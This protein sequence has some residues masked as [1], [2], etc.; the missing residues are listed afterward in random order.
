MVKEY[1]MPI[2]LWRRE[3]CEHDRGVAGSDGHGELRGNRACEH[4][5]L[6]RVHGGLPQGDL[7]EGHG[8]DGG[9]FLDIE[10]YPNNLIPENIVIPGVVDVEEDKGT[11]TKKI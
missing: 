11:G 9:I 5:P 1:L 8:F 4:Q 7:F 10:K 6:G 2:G 3:G